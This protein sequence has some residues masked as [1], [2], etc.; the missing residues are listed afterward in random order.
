[1]KKRIIAWLLG[2]LTEEGFV[3]AFGRVWVIAQL[4]ISYGTGSDRVRI[5]GLSIREL[6]NIKK[7]REEGCSP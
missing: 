2:Q 1:M 7:Q 4:E 5:D 6:E 3:F